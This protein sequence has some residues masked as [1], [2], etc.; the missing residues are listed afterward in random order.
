MKIFT[1]MLAFLPTFAL[2]ETDIGDRLRAEY[3]T[4]RAFV[5]KLEPDFEVAGYLLGKSYGD[6]E[7]L[8][9]LEEDPN[10]SEMIRIL[11]DKGDKE[12]AFSISFHTGTHIVRDHHVIRRFVGPDMTGWRND[13]ADSSSGEYFGTQGTRRPS[14]DTRDREILRDWDIELFDEK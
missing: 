1:L 2:A 10:E 4:L 9:H 12:Q 6:H 3:Q 11:R 7:I 13:T 8:W 14:L 5:S